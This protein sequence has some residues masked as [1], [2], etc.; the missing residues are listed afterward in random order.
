[1][2]SQILFLLGV[3]PVWDER[4]LVSDVKLIPRAT[5]GRPRIDVFIAA[6]SYYQMNLPSRM[7]LIDK[8]IRLV[9]AEQEADN[10]VRVNSDR[11]R[12]TLLAKGLAPERAAGLAQARIF[13]HPPGQFGD[14]SYYYL[15]ERSGTWDTR[16]ELIERYLAQ[17]KH[18]YTRDHW[19]ED[20]PEAYN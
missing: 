1:M 11:L 7:E 18:V 14:P 5:L 10:T 6:G 17:V 2:E 8:A 13:G 12:Q 20:A 4:N 15:V 19:G 9:A 3:E 16:E